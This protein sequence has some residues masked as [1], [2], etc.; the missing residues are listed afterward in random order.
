MCSKPAGRGSARVNELSAYCTQVASAPVAFAG[1][2]PLRDTGQQAAPAQSGAAWMTSRPFG[3]KFHSRISARKKTRRAATREVASRCTVA[4]GFVAHHR[5][6][7]A[8]VYALYMRR[9][10]ANGMRMSTE[11]ALPLEMKAPRLGGCQTSSMTILV[12]SALY[13]NMC[14]RTRLR[15][16]NSSSETAGSPTGKPLSVGTPSMSTVPTTACDAT[17]SAAPRCSGSALNDG[18]SRKLPYSSGGAELAFALTNVSSPCA[19]RRTV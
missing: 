14:R 17:L 19:A 18:G 15:G 5:L 13:A 9:T 12:A 8:S 3:A 11:R 1:A 10:P 4:P 6:D 7:V 2:A 16:S